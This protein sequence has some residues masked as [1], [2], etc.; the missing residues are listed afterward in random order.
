LQK[1]ETAIANGVQRRPQR[2]PS[3]TMME[4]AVASVRSAIEAAD[5]NAFDE[6]FGMLTKT[7]NLCHEAERVPFVHVALPTERLSP[8]R[9]PTPVPAPEERGE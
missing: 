4:G 5:P 7:C 9:A 8:V 6:A 1:I 2:A 3:A